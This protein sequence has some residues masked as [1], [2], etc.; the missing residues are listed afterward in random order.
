MVFCQLPVCLFVLHTA[1]CSCTDWCSEINTQNQVHLQTRTTYKFDLG[2]VL[3]PPRMLGLGMLA[4]RKILERSLIILIFLFLS[5]SFCLDEWC[6]FFVSAASAFCAW[7][8]NVL[9]F[10]LVQSPSMSSKQ[11]WKNSEWRFDLISCL[12]SLESSLQLL[13][14]RKN[15]MRLAI[16]STLQKSASTDTPNC[17]TVLLIR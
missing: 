12:S 9:L 2:S 4:T 10:H 5:F 11:S 16:T 3:I 6:C 8:K 14:G 17:F 1:P 7:A 15:S 13:G